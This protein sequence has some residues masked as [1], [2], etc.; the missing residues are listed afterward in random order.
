MP[1][2]RKIGCAALLVLLGGMGNA[3]AAADDPGAAAR[4][5]A[6]ALQQETPTLVAPSQVTTFDGQ[7]IDPGLA[8]Q[9]SALIS[10]G[11]LTATSIARDPAGGM[12]I[13]T[14]SGSLVLTPTTTDPGA[15]QGTIVNGD[16]VVFAGTGASTD[17]V[18]RP[19]ALGVETFQQLHDENAPRVFSWQ[20]QLPSSAHL[21]PLD[22]STIAVVTSTP[23]TAASLDSAA[24]ADGLSTST[25]ST[26]PPIDDP[27]GQPASEPG[28]G[29]R[30]TAPAETVTDTTTQSNSQSA[31]GEQTVAD[32]QS[33][34]QSAQDDLGKA[35]KDVPSGY[36]IAVVSAPWVTDANGTN[37]PAT[38]EAS[39]TRSP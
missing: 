5:A 18:V 34:I 29:A 3:V 30:S 33:Q 8:S 17:T 23:P 14:G 11:S 35:G 36:V 24:T 21:V 28:T 9:G 39:G 19:T 25:A 6:S 37:V 20:A 16:A 32:A 27:P 22:D 26:T 4:S 15:S 13:T 2:S 31:P 1:L 10:T 38:L 7:T 12:S